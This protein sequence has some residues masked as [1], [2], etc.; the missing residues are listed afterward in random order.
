MTKSASIQ[1]RRN[2]LSLSCNYCKRRKVKCDRGRP[3]SACLR[4]NVADQCEYPGQVWQAP[5]GGATI[6]VQATIPPILNANENS[7]HNAT[8][9]TSETHKFHIT[10]GP[11]QS[12]PKAVSQ[13]RTSSNSTEKGGPTVPIFSDYSVL[14]NTAFD[15]S[16]SQLQM[17]SADTITQESNGSAY[18][19]TPTSRKPI[20]SYG[21]MSFNN[22]VLPPLTRIPPRGAES[23][24]RNEPD[25]LARNSRV[26]SDLLP[27]S[28][29]EYVPR[30]ET[31]VGVNIYD[32]ND[33]NDSINLYTGYSPIHVM[34]VS[35]HLNHGPFSWMS[36]MKRDGAL[37]SILNHL[38]QTKERRTIHPTVNHLIQIQKQEKKAA[39]GA[40]AEFQARVLAREGLDD[41]DPYEEKEKEEKEKEEKEKED[42]KEDG[43]THKVKRTKNVRI[44]AEERSQMNKNAI[45]LGLTVFAGKMDQELRVIE[46][47]KVILPKQKVIW[48]L[49]KEYF[50]S[51]YP[52]I[53]LIDE[54]S[55]TT[56]LEKILGA[57][58]YNDEEVP[59]F[60]IERRID[61]CTVG[62]LLVVLRIT[63]L[64]KFSNK[65]Q[66]NEYIINSNEPRLAELKYI[67]TNPINIDVISFAQVCL[68]QFNLMSKTNLNIIQL[69]LIL[70]V[71]RIFSPE[72]GDG[73]D[74]GESQ[75]YNGV[76]ARMAFSFGLNREPDLFDDVCNDEKVNHLSRKIWFYLNTNDIS[77]SSQ[78][79]TP[80][81]I[82]EEYCD[83]KLPFNRT[84]NS[85]IVDLQ[86]ETVVTESIQ[87][88]SKMLQKQKR[89]LTMTLSVRKWIKMSELTAAVSEF[90]LD[91]ARYYGSLSHYTR[92]PYVPN[93]YPFIKVKK[94]KSYMNSK[95]FTVSLYFYIYLHYE[96]RNNVDLSFFYMRKLF[97]IIYGE[98]VPEYMELVLNNHRN[99]DPN[100]TMADL[101]LNPYLQLMIHKCAQLSFSFIYRLNYNIFK[102][103]EDPVLH[104]KNL[105][106]DTN[107][108]LRFAKLC[109]LSKMIERFTKYGIKCLSRLS[110][111]YY[112]AWRICKAHAHVIE[113]LTSEKFYRSPTSVSKGFL[114]VSMDQMNELIKIM[115]STLRRIKESLEVSEGKVPEPET[116][117]ASPNIGEN[118]R[119]LIFAN[120]LLESS[121]SPR[122]VGTPS[123]PN[124]FNIPLS[125]E[126]DSSF[127]FDGG[128]QNNSEIDKLW[129]QMVS[130]KNEGNQSNSEFNGS[131]SNFYVGPIAESAPS[132]EEDNGGIT[133]MA[134]L[135][136]ESS[137]FPA[138]LLTMFSID[139]LFNM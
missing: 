9:N 5:S 7:K 95:I 63:Y 129:L 78:Y 119:N 74:G 84:G 100:S 127:E 52:F 132:V 77:L 101:I 56:A 69:G 103:K 125:T 111:R 62:I 24:I 124:V 60:K 91:L 88:G 109:R 71:Y 102:L 90:E 25:S 115:D 116:R 113:L 27:C 133:G 30:I 112:Y 61:F 3:C 26:D 87:Q 18:D 82:D 139:Q 41:M 80:L 120:V 48:T 126:T 14:P 85:N 134:S 72:D 44:S 97:A 21:I 35:S 73:A 39:Q 23:N 68:D 117:V 136:N 98:F 6:S 31:Y 76:L 8:I 107:Y 40:E 93:P 66:I 137:D 67:L 50:R 81:D 121:E 34:D 2:R 75:A 105:R 99:F 54:I 4:H 96:E 65:S 17:S 37:M 51:I 22:L 49:V 47:I 138:D 92:T 53:P 28:E 110:N 135:G 10:T 43:A 1:K 59:F 70:R 46:K 36:I 19:S 11:T 128:Y 131:D 13:R 89:L 83:T 16:A 108:R 38:S 57:E 118:G 55:F 32:T 114:N 104:S 130:M 15:E 123:Y 12:K 64:S 20:P 45:A 33:P 29:V 106:N 122:F 42:Q 86:L 94:C 79:G 58:E